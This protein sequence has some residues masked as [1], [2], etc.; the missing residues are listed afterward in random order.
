MYVEVLEKHASWEG[1]KRPL[2]QILVV[3][4]NIQV[5]ILKAEVEK[6]FMV[7]EVDHEWTDPKARINLVNGGDEGSSEPWK[8]S[9]PSAER[10]NG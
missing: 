6:G 5:R 4:A 2:V 7:T 9:P 1:V 8:K 3:V 10:E